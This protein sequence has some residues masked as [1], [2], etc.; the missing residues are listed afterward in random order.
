MLAPTLK[1]ADPI[2]QELPLFARSARASVKP[3]HI[4]RLSIRVALRADARWSVAFTNALLAPPLP[5][6]QELFSAAQNS[7]VLRRKILGAYERPA[8]AFPWILDPKSTR[9]IIARY[10]K[11]E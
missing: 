3:R 1:Y 2:A 10:S 6:V 4:K 11:S 7:R 9:S 5:H 8:S